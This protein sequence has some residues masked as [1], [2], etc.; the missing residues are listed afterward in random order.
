VKVFGET[1]EREYGEL[2]LAIAEARS[3]LPEIGG[4]DAAFVRTCAS[5]AA[6]VAKF[7]S[8]LTNGQLKQVRAMME[9]EFG[10]RQLALNLPS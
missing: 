7:L 8:V 4:D 5:H 2:K 9:Q 10:K 3:S 1:E 6:V